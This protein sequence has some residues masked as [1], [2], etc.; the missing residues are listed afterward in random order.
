MNF[1]SIYMLLVTTSPLEE[2]RKILTKK[3]DQMASLPVGFSHGEGFPVTRASI[4][5]AQQF[6]RWASDQ[7]VEADVFPNLDGGCAV[8]F[9]KDALKVEVSISPDGNRFDLRIEHGI[10]L[11]FENL[12]EPRENVS[13]A[14]IQEIILALRGL[15]NGIWKSSASSTFVNTTE[16][17]GAFGIC[18]SKTPPS[19]P[20]LPTVKGG[21]QSS[22]LFVPAAMRI[23]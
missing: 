10:G 2:R 18:S 19:K 22:R 6:V 4:S 16:P 14:E 12:T 5:V 21:S 9:Y 20:I 13:R 7:A 15:N 3:L 23:I 17:L 11:Q 1:D 8:A